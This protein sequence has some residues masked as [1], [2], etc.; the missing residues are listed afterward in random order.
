MKPNPKKAHLEL[1]RVRFW[2]E[3]N[4]LEVISVEW[5][6]HGYDPIGGPPCLTYPCLRPVDCADE[7]VIRS[8]QSALSTGIWPILHFGRPAFLVGIDQL[9][10]CCARPTKSACDRS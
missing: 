8:A 6:Q 7:E 2:A 3:F 9:D 5:A 10:I 4:G 1:L